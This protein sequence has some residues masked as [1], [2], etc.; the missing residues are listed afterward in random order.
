MLSLAAT[1]VRTRY[2]SPMRRLQCD[3]TDYTDHSVR[4]RLHRPRILRFA[5][6]AHLQRRLLRQ[7]HLELD[8]APFVCVYARVHVCAHAGV[9]IHKHPR[10]HTGCMCACGRVHPQAPTHACTHHTH[11]HMHAPRVPTCSA[12]CCAGSICGRLA[13]PGAP[14]P[15]YAPPP[16][17]P[18]P[19]PAAAAVGPPGWPPMRAVGAPPMTAVG[20]GWEWLAMDGKPAPTAAPTQLRRLW[21]A[22]SGLLVPAPGRGEGRAA[23]KEVGWESACIYGE[24]GVKCA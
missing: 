19:T 8:Q 17:I 15:P 20:C 12:D 6:H 1:H 23:I 18:M 2:A 5:C 10:A 14:M 11:V 22:A 7:Q 16:P 13:A 24:R 4:C 9:C 21:S 3:C